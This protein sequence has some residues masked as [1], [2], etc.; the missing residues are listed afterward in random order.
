M[1]ISIDLAWF[2]T[3]ILNLKSVFDLVIEGTKLLAH[4]ISSNQKLANLIDIVWNISS[5]FLAHA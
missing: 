3:G 4:L 5:T 2:C 1:G